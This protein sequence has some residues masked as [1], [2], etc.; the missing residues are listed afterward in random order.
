MFK[1]QY[2]E[3]F[4]A[5]VN[6]LEVLKFIALCLNRYKHDRDE[7]DANKCNMFYRLGKHE[8]LKNVKI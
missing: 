6:D 5:L 3:T 7:S 2:K 1:F 8:S 4:P